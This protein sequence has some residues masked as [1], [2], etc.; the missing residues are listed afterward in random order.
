MSRSRRGK[1]GGS[2]HRAFLLLLVAALVAGGWLWLRYQGFADAP[3]AGIET[4]DSLV[5]ERGDSLGSVLRKLQAEG[6]ATGERLQWQVLARE[7]DAAGR[8]Q[9]GEYALDAGTSPRAL[10]LAMRDGKVVRRGFT[11][12]EGW[13]IRDLRAALATRRGG[14][15][16]GTAGCE[17]YALRIASV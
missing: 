11:V 14:E 7:L 9:V 6:I 10:L 1:P 2:V 4:G 17:G 12:I 13:N 8:L 3:L 16:S 5:V 15:R